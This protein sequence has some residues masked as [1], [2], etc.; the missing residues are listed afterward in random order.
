[1]TTRLLKI[2]ERHNIPILA[3]HVYV[4]IQIIIFFLSILY[5]SFYITGNLSLERNKEKNNDIEQ[6]ESCTFKGKN[7]KIREN[8]T[9][10]THK[11]CD[12]CAKYRN[13]LT[14]YSIQISNEW[15]K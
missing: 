15:P 13:C 2:R 6:C 14:C 11:A 4:K 12:N 5:F 3:R 10:K 7:V 1:M 9:C 8:W